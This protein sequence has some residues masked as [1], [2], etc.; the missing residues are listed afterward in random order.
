MSGSLLDNI[1]LFGDDVDRARLQRAGELACIDEFVKALP[2][3]YNSLVGD[4]GSMMSAGQAQR[5]LLARVFY[6]QAKI[7]FLDEATAN[8]D[9]ETEQR[10]L[11]NLMNCGATIVMVSHRSAPIAMANRVYRCQAGRLSCENENDL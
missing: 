4:M 7:L 2:M 3:G 9:L 11:Q 8:L 5:V 6:K 1:C 10:V